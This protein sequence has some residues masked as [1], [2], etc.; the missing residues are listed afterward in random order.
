MHRHICTP[1]NMD[2]NHL[3]RQMSDVL[4]TPLGPGARCLSLSRSCHWTSATQLRC[5]DLCSSP[6]GWNVKN[7]T[8]KPG[9]P[10]CLH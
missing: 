9:K 7:L 10:G 5:R 3:R 4:C 6:A 1:V 2:T 8:L